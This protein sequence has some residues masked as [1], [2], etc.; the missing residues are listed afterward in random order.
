MWARYE[1]GTH[2]TKFYVGPWIFY[3]WVILYVIQ[4]VWI[5]YGWELACRKTRAGNFFE[6]VPVVP[7]IVYVLAVLSYAGFLG[8]LA[9]WTSR[10]YLVYSPLVMLGSTICLYAA[11]A[12]AVVS[13]KR[14]MA[15][16]SNVSGGRY[17]WEV[18][19]LVHN[20]LGVA[21]TWATIVL[22]YSVVLAVE[23]AGMLPDATEGFIFLSLLGAYTVVW[24]TLD[25]SIA[26]TYVPHLLTPYAVLIVTLVMVL[27]KTGEGFTYYFIYAIVMLIV[28]A[29]LFLVR[30]SMAIGLTT[31]LHRKEY[32]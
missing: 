8:W 24:F 15:V 25:L 28:T 30:I 18:R 7:T 31:R 13:L 32:L 16:L 2:N 19:L 4:L 26:Q 29:V 17:L 23:E 22:F 6:H 27:M 1:S 5:L 9:L 14:Y 3:I 21:A 20:G 12:L 11:M 10:D